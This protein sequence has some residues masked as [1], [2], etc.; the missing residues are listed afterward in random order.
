MRARARQGQLIAILLGLGLAIAACHR[1]A[2]R[3]P[4]W[5]WL[6]A[7]LLTPQVL[8]EAVWEAVDSAAAA[9][10][11][12]LV[13]EVKCRTGE[14]LV[15]NS[16]FPYTKI[17]PA[18]SGSGDIL[19]MAAER[20]A[21]RGMRVAAGI[22]V[23]YGGN[24]RSRQG[25][26]WQ[27][28]GD[29]C[30]T[31]ITERGL[32]RDDEDPERAWVRFSPAIPEVRQAELS[33][34]DAVLSRPEC[35]GAW[36]VGAEF[37]DVWSDV[38]PRAREGFQ[39]WLGA[40][41]RTWPADVCVRDSTG[42]LR[43]GKWFPQWIL[44]RAMVIRDFVARAEE[45]VA[46]RHPGKWLGIVVGGW[47]PR[48]FQ[49]GV[50]WAQPGYDH[51][52]RWLVAGYGQSSLATVGTRLGIGLFFAAVSEKEAKRVVAIPEEASFDPGW[53]SVEGC[54][55]RAKGALTA[56]SWERTWAVV[57]L[58]HYQGDWKKARRALRSA[59]SFA[60]VVLL[61]AT[62]LSAERWWARLR[63]E[64]GSAK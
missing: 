24:K 43:P 4:V 56:E 33:F 58:G 62:Q 40:E 13:V 39:D 60:G 22:H 20:A 45:A 14:A 54:V 48:G 59:R 3:A 1:P 27:G 46:S 55:R 64:L 5:V 52:N 28:M 63:S 57:H 29:W 21:T 38:G 47:L 35:E 34:L 15:A 9:G 42:V 7:G 26:A 36:L 19:R 11:E 2:A 12:G 51:R 53:L 61:D 10:A 6:D 17:S 23:F 18:S 41:V 8:P 44:W 50:N 49:E 31:R 30:V 32:V 37:P 25:L 16:A